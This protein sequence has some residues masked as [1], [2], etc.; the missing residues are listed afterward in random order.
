MCWQYSLPFSIWLIY[1]D[2][3]MQAVSI[4]LLAV[5]YREPIFIL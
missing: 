2:S 3:L 5:Y 4:Y 1:I